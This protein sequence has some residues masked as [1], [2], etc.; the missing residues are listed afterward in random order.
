MIIGI[1][2]WPRVCTCRG[3]EISGCWWCCYEKSW[4]EGG[5]Y[6][7]FLHSIMLHTTECELSNISTVLNRHKEVSSACLLLLYEFFSSFQYPF[8]LHNLSCELPNISVVLNPWYYPIVVLVQARRVELM[9]WSCR[10]VVI[11]VVC[12]KM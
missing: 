10:V 12:E 6:Y 1:H 7:I 11:N 9:T 2:S 8:P 3:K 5:K 4:W